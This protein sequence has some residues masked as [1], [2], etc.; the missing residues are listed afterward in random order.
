MF[1]S[2]LESLV[3]LS[4]DTNFQATLFTL[5]I[6]GIGFTLSRV[7]DWLKDKRIYKNEYY[8]KLIDKRFGAYEVI[9]SILAS[10]Q[11]TVQSE[12][13]EYHSFF[14]SKKQFDEFHR[15]VMSSSTGQLYT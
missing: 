12:T 3:K 11:I 2:I 9:E 1:A 6:G 8:K 14:Q 4:K 10:M 15:I 7:L 13:N 5:L